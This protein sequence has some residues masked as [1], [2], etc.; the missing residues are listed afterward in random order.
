METNNN[1]RCRF[2]ENRIDIQIIFVLISKVLQ[3]KYVGSYNM[4]M[5]N[6][7]EEFHK[8]IHLNSGSLPIHKKT[9]KLH[10]NEIPFGEKVLFCTL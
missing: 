3:T 2:S 8:N 4:E 1:T 5:Q 10:S 6:T 9:F 7:D